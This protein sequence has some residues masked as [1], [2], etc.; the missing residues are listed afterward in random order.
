MKVLYKKIRFK[1][2]LSFGKTFTEIDL[3]S[4][5]KTAIFGVNGV[6]KST[7]LCAI[8]FALF[9]KPFRK[10]NKPNII[11][12]IN[13]KD[14]VVELEFSVGSKE[15]KVI[16][17]LKP[18][19]FEIY[20]DGILLNQDAASRDYQEYL[21]KNIIGTNYKSF[22]QVVILG[23]A[24]YVPFMS[25]AAAD[26]RAVIE[27]LLDIQ[28]FTS[29]N[30]LI[31]DKLSNIKTKITETSYSIDILKEKIKHQKSII[32]DNTKQKESTITK[33]QN[34]IQ[35]YLTE[36]KNY[37]LEITNLQENITQLTQQIIDKSSIEAKKQ[38]LLLVENK[39]TDS[40]RKINKQIE[41]YSHNDNCP[42]CK[43][44]IAQDFKQQ[45][46]DTAEDKKTKLEEGLE[47]LEQ[48][49]T[50]LNNKINDINVIANVISN[51]QREITKLNATIKSYE[52]F[53]KELNKE[54]KEL[55]TSVNSIN[56]NQLQTLNLEL[57]TLE[58]DYNELL[59]DKKYLEYSATLLKDGGIKTKIIKQYLP[60]LNKLINNYLSKFQFFVNFNINE[61]FE[62]VIKSRNRDAFQY[63]SFSEG[64]KTKIDLSILLAF[65]ELSKLKNSVSCNLLLLDEIIDSSLDNE[66]IELFLDLL[67]EL[68][69]NTNI[70][71]I[72]PKADDLKD[73]FD[74][75]IRVEMV[76]NFSKLKETI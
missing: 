74:R 13:K 52:N 43:Q 60:V 39:A 54:I 48:D 10:I 27:D 12:S 44:I 28:I 66:S 26:R 68:D 64:Q 50:D 61:N 53:I 17:G 59:N 29:M 25:L 30:T 23:S 49:L 14:C 41:F 55:Q 1:N 7:L 42:T 51:N 70:F 57:G 46:L 21:E 69:Y 20:Q 65:R 67:D 47:K 9:G 40:L 22:I 4:H 11:N 71:V 75:S 45:K 56:D 63:N 6:G 31:K 38:K 3:T 76:K 2:F 15:Y 24:R 33:K 35:Y 18:N 72:S 62:E 19:I 73:R 5:K 34:D 37:E 32:N 58:E 36:N 8:T 16:R